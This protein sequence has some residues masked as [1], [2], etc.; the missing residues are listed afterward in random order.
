MRVID[1]KGEQLG[2]MPVLQAIRIAR[3]KELD[4]V[5]V[6]PTSVPPVCRLLDYGRFKYQQIKKEKEARKAQHLA[7]LREIRIRPKI[8][9]HDLDS[10][11]KQTRKL[12]EEGDKVKVSVVFRGREA[13]HPELGRELMRRVLDA[14]KESSAVERPLAM[15]GRNMTAIL[16][17][18]LSAKQQPKE[19]AKEAAPASAQQQAKEP[20]KAAAPAASPQQKKEPAKEAVKVKETVKEA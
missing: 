12:L 9:S 7:L 13:S 10:K 8:D 14:L 2:V 17:P 18:P 20:V 16:A 19:P 15:E 1:E 11:I 6:A 5:E 3:E 4:L